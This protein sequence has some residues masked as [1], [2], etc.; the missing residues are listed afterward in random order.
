MFLPPNK[1]KKK[2]KKKKECKFS[3]F[4]FFFLEKTIANANAN[5]RTGVRIGDV[6]DMWYGDTLMDMVGSGNLSKGRIRESKK[7]RRKEK[8][9]A[10]SERASPMRGGH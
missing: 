10:E 1:A 2:K 5:M 7:E 9:G 3:F 6:N 4:F 8:G